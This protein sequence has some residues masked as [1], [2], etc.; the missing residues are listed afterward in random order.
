MSQMAIRLGAALLVAATAGACSDG[1][2]AAPASNADIR[3]ATQLDGP[4][5]SHEVTQA[6]RKIVML[7]DCLASDAAWPGGCTLASGRVTFTQFQAVLPKGHPAWRNEPSYL[8]IGEQKDVKIANEGGRTHT[9]THVAQY[10]NGIVPNANRPGEAIA[11]EC[12]NSATRLASLLA[13]GQS[14]RLED[15]APGIHKY[16]CCFHPWMI[17]EIR[18][19]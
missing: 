7:D 4:S 3:A 5:F 13:P 6:P 11:P 2:V 15:L 18:V 10:G 8:K 9:F 14:A 1:P 17:A 19:L 16:M 12:L